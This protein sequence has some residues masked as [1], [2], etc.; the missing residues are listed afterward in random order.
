MYS[1]DAYQMRD[2]QQEDFGR[3]GIPLLEQRTPDDLMGAD[4]EWENKYSDFFSKGEAEDK[5][6]RVTIPRYMGPKNTRLDV[7]DLKDSDIQTVEISGIPNHAQPTCV[8]LKQ[9]FLFEFKEGVRRT[10]AYFDRPFLLQ[11]QYKSIVWNCPQSSQSF[12]LYP[13]IQARLAPY[14][15]DAQHLANCTQFK[16]D[17]IEADSTTQNQEDYVTRWLKISV[18]EPLLGFQQGYAKLDAV[19]PMNQGNYVYPLAIQDYSLSFNRYTGTDRLKRMLRDP[20]KPTEYTYGSLTKHEGLFGPELPSARL[21]FSNKANIVFRK[22]S[23][24]DSRICAYSE[25]SSNQDNKNVSSIEMHCPFFQVYKKPVILSAEA[26][27]L[28]PG[29]IGNYYTHDQPIG[30][31]PYFPRFNSR[32]A[33]ILGVDEGSEVCRIQCNTS[34]GYPS[35]ILVYLEEFGRNYYDPD[36]FTS[37][38]TES[39][40]DLLVGG[41]P[42]IHELQ[43]KLFGQEFPITKSLGHQELDYLTKKNSHPKCSFYEHMKYDPIVLLK[44]EDLG[45]GTESIGYPNSKRLEMEVVINQIMLPHGWALQYAPNL[46]IVNNLPKPQ[47]TANVVFIYE[48]HILEGTNGSCNFVWKY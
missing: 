4:A 38:A 37:I 20:R 47:I 27:D 43:I 2:Y 42:H 17:I 25:D 39:G 32:T 35:F 26:V 13:Q 48:N 6:K 28:I 8:Y 22:I 16:C 31:M 46:P 23:E 30:M 33:V 44:L 24:T 10:L 41:H 36:M 3:P 12:E 45:L 1:R 11:R 40:T 21:D 14:L 5:N 34:K 15:C 9:S 29:L 18:S 7:Y 19:R